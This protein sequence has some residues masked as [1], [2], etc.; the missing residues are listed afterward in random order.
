[1]PRQKLSEYRAKTILSEA[2]KLPYSGWPVN[3]SE[4]LDSQLSLAAA[5]SGNFVVK[6]DEG[7][8]GR[9]KKGLVAL[10]V[11]AAKLGE[12]VD[13]ISSKGYHWLIVEPMVNHDQ[14]DER[15][16]SIVVDREGPTLQYSA[17]GGGR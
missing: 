14:K 12:A 6:V 2:L 3:A 5:A 7:V 4:P 11:E 8:K 15:Y 13:Q 16:M 10:N 1:M 17:S 9:F